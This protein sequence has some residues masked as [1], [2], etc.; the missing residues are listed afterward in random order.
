MNTVYAY[1]VVLLYL[2]IYIYSCG[3]KLTVWIWCIIV[4]TYWVKWGNDNIVYAIALRKKAQF[5]GT[6]ETIPS[7][8]ALWR[9]PGNTMHRWTYETSKIRDATVIQ[10]DILYPSIIIIILLNLKMGIPKCTWIWGTLIGNMTINQGFW[11][12]GYSI[13][14]TNPNVRQ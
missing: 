5:M 1:W 7:W 10:W 11:A 4:Y 2:C 6:H 8:V 3:F 14:N 12:L 9:C 13:S